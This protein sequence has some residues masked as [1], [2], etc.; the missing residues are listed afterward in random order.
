MI[1][2]YQA[3]TAVLT[4]ANSGM[5]WMLLTP[6]VIRFLVVFLNSGLAPAKLIV[7]LFMK[8]YNRLP[9]P[10]LDY[11][12]AMR[13]LVW[14]LAVVATGASYLSGHTPAEMVTTLLAGGAGSIGLHET[15]Q[16]LGA[17]IKPEKPV[18]T[19]GGQSGIRL[20]QPPAES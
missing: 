14:V 10:D 12:H 20:P 3:L 13:A 17:L 11:A 5:G 1:E 7:Q 4:A 9:T 8:L 19:N 15:M 6:I 16:S 18:D 2:L